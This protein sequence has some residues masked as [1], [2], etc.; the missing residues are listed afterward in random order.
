MGTAITP[1]Q[2]AALSRLVEEVVLALDADRP[3]Q[4]A[5]LRAQRVAGEPQDA[6]AG[7]GDAGGRGPGGDDRP[8]GGATRL[9]GADRATRS[10]WP[11]SRS[12][13]ASTTPT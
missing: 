12:A 13:G 3:G 9:Q 11:P 10:S 6:A 5:M 1:E 7:G 4:E 8:S 2:V